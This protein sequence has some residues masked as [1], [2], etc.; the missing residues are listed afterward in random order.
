MTIR[1]IL[2]DLGNTLLEYAQAGRWREFRLKR[3]EEMYPAVREELGVIGISAGEF[4]ASMG[5]VIGGEKA[6]AIEASGRSWHFAERLREGLAAVGLRADESALERLTGIFYE[7]IRAGTK[8]YPETREMLGRLRSLGTKLAIITNSPW[9]TPGRLLR[10]DLERWGLAGFFQAFICSGDVPWRKPNPAFM[11]AAAAAL[12][13]S[14]KDCLGVGDSPETDIAGARA[15][16]MRSAWVN[17][18]GRPQREG[19][20]GPDF[21]IGDLRQVERL[22]REAG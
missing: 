8:P 16:G 12:G 15:A 1:A 9:D 21:V 22:A 7:P 3:L 2:F 14:A 10:G 6:R 11:L 4:A 5:E 18:E 20:S 13:V 17:R 19:G